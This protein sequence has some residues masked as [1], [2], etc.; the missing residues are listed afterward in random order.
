MTRSGAYCRTLITSGVVVVDRRYL[1]RSS[2]QLVK[3]RAAALR[4]ARELARIECLLRSSAFTPKLIKILN[5]TATEKRRRLK[6]TVT[7]KWMCVGR[8][9]RPHL[10]S[11]RRPAPRS[12]PRLN[13]YSHARLYPYPCPHPHPYPRPYPYLYLHSYP[14]PYLYPNCRSCPRRRNCPWFASLRLSTLAWK[15]ILHLKAYG[16]R[17]RR[18][19]ESRIRRASSRAPTHT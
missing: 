16:R 15:A 1:R 12:H 13:P 4:L 2:G 8:R 3:A 10:R 19:E 7:V 11:D 14:C 5:T 6:V 9:G 17:Q 18:W